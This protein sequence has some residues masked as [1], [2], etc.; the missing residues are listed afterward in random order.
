MPATAHSTTERDLEFAIAAAQHAGERA[1][2]LRE[3]GRWKDEK[4]LGDIA[5]Q[6]C[7]GYLQGLIRGRYPNDGLLSE[8]TADSPARLSKERVWIVDPLDG[9]KEYGQGRADWAV[10]V[11]LTQSGRCLLAAVALPSEQRVLW[12]YT[13]QG[14]EQAGVEGAG[15][16]ASGATTPAGPPRIAVSR[17]HTPEWTS[18][19]AHALGTDQQIP[20]G[21]AGFKV[22]RLLFGEA[23]VYVHSK[24]LKEWDT[25]AP[26]TVARALGWSVCR[27]RGDEHRYN[28]PDPKNHELVICRP[29][30]KERVLAAIRTCGV[31][32]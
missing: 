20:W 10:H 30:L 21:S 15:E 22:S 3:S 26:E 17:S 12:G 4:L 16:L 14:R 5:D 1:L 6:A 11:A 19:F 18:A 9:T 13:L 31:L 29:A 8:E 25:C 23:D 2:R 32:G 27:L 7:D 28:C 24:G